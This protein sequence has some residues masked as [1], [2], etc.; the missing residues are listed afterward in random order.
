MKNEKENIDL[1]EMPKN[2]RYRS[3]LI[4]LYPDSQTYNIDDIFFEL[5]G[6]KDYAY[7][8]HSPESDEK[9]IHIHLYIYLPNACTK[10][11]VSKR[12]GVPEKFIQHARSERACLRYLTHI[13]DSEKTQYTIDTVICSKSLER[14]LIK[15]HSD[16]ELETDIID[17]IYNFILN[18]SLQNSNYQIALINLV[19]FVNMNCYDTIY[20]RYRSEFKEYM[21]DLFS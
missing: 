9:K 1:V 20:K 13:D 17:N 10:S 14:K 4:L 6:F 21:L 12:L 3:W 15:A 11:A 7:I 19:K 5:R 16:I 18:E 2:D 8:Y